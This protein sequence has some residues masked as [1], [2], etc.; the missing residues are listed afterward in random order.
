MEAAAA[1]KSAP[2]SW[3]GVAFPHFQWTSMDG[4][5]E[6]NF[7]PRFSVHQVIGE[8]RFTLKW[9]W[10]RLGS[11][12]TAA[13]C[14]AAQV[15]LQFS[16]PPSRCFSLNLE[17]F[18]TYLGWKSLLLEMLQLYWCREGFG[19]LHNKTIAYRCS[20]HCQLHV[21]QSASGIFSLFVLNRAVRL[22][23]QPR[24]G[25]CSVCVCLISCRKCWTH[26]P[27]PLKAELNTP[28]N[29]AVP[30]CRG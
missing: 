15:Q 28:G 6:Q 11:Q 27:A 23:Q 25:L 14:S 5:N 10:T 7:S 8:L 24:E 17:R 21:C 30:L 29:V 12:E 22:E 13:C 16:L 20:E 26:F 9:L 2:L 18:S 19:S 1:H 4:E 3:Q